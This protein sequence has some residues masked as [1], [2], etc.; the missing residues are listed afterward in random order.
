MSF[1]TSDLDGKLKMLELSCFLTL[2]KERS[3][4]HGGGWPG[5][6]PTSLHVSARSKKTKNADFRAIFQVSADAAKCRKRGPKKTEKKKNLANLEGVYLGR[7]KGGNS[8]AR[9]SLEGPKRKG[10][11]AKGIFFGKPKKKTKGFHSFKGRRPIL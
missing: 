7:E 9:G 1:Q 8:F 5:G 4:H 11:K 6:E 2:L 10:G 3:K